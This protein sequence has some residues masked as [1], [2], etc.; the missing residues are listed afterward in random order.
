MNRLPIYMM[1]AAAT[2]VALPLLLGPLPA[3]ASDWP[4]FRGAHRDGLSDEKGLLR[5]W[6]QTGPK[7]AWRRPIGPG[8]SGVAVA[9]GRLYTMFA[10]DGDEG[11]GF[12]AALDPATGKEIWRVAVA[13]RLDTQFGN[14]PRATPTV[15]KDVVYVM[16]SRGTVMALAAKDGA[17]RWKLE[18]ADAFSSKVPTWGH[19][20]SVVVD[21]GKVI[22]EAGGPGEGKSYAGIDAASGKVLWTSG[23]GPS[24]AGYMSPL[25]VD[26]AG[27]H[28]YVYVMGAPDGPPGGGAPPMSA[29][30]SVDA[31]GKELWSL[32]WPSGETHATPV[33]VPPDRLFVSGV[34]GI[35]GAMLKVKK[36]AGK[37]AVEEIWK[38]PMFRTHFNAAVLHGDHLYGFDNTTLKCISVKDGSIAWAKR[39]LGKGS[40]IE[41]DGLLMVLSDDGRLLLVEANPASYTE[42]GSV[43]ALKPEGGRAWT[44]PTLSGGRVYVRNHAELVAY[45][46]KG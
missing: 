31:S 39:G 40:L 5:A 33:L 26:L 17:A 10:E 18:L 16:G 32:P 46:V 38:N 43:Q 34:E 36:D 37:L 20:A 23:N 3:Q 27:V 22:L 7:E 19:T 2:A 8:Y 11:Q 41:A 1:R 28:Q 24:E 45:D 4:Q 6:P 21:G 15:D 30:R 13:K 44:P 42:K 12:A 14:G 25:V 35:G 9:G 29:L